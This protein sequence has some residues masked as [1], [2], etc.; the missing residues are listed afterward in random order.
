[1]RGMQRGVRRSA[2]AQLSHKRT[3]YHFWHTY[4]SLKQI[5]KRHLVIVL[6]VVHCKAETHGAAFASSLAPLGGE[7][8]ALAHIRSTPSSSPPAS[9]HRF[10]PAA[11]FSAFPDSALCGG[12]GFVGGRPI[13]RHVKPL[14]AQRQQFVYRHRRSPSICQAACLTFSTAAPSTPLFIQIY[15]IYLSD[16]F[17]HIPPKNTLLHFFSYLLLIR[18][19]SRLL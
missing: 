12:E 9:S 7:P 11:L 19:L 2:I 18:L 8:I 15:F 4:S 17:P 16:A 5:S 1:M 10:P 14:S 6:V 3:M 13:H